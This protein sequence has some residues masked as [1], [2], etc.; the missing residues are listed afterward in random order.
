M[1]EIKTEPLH[2]TLETPTI[3]PRRSTLTNAD[4]EAKLMQQEEEPNTMLNLAIDAVTTPRSTEE[5]EAQLC[6]ARR[7]IKKS[8]D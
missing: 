7:G 6:R 8:L 3:N 1:E 5:F 2:Q 4:I